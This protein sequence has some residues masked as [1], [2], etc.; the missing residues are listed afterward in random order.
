MSNWIAGC[1][2]FVSL[3]A[4]Y[5]SYAQFMLNRR[6]QREASQPY[7]VPDIQ[8]RAGGSGILVFTLENVGSTVARKVEI[9]VDPPLQGGERDDWDEKLRVALSRKLSHLPPG[10]RLE[11][12]FAY[13]PRFYQITDLPRQYTVKVRATGPSGP[14]EEMSYLIDLDLMQETAL[15]RETVISKL[16]EIAKHLSKRAR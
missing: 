3:V 2:A 16:G 9:N 11:W 12:Y 8:P 1:A 14:V 6:I 4:L 15:E 13:G 5:F 7:V 10:R